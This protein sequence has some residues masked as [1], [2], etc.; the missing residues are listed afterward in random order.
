MTQIDITERQALQAERFA[1]SVRWRRTGAVILGW[2][3]FIGLWA[4]LSQLVFG[5]YM[6]PGPLKIAIFMW[7]ELISTG[8]FLSHFAISIGKVFAGFGIA[9]IIGVPVGYLMGT[10]RYWKSFFHDPVMVTGSIP[11]ITYAVLSLVIFGI[12]LGGPILAVALVSMVY[13]AI[14]VAEGLEGVD[15]GLV[16][17]SHAYRRR[18]RDI[19][20]HVLIPSILPFAFAGIRLSFALAWKVEQLT[21]VFGSSSGVGLMIRKEYEDFSITGVLAWVLLFIGFM[22]LIERFVLVELERWLF[23]WRGPEEEVRR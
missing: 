20:R 16:Q 22:L 7:E 23:R 4:L 13:V 6:L 10:S 11:G 19:L 1:A 12:S 21:E 2:L 17:M 5:P 18:Q 3:G 15:R 9:V 14:N 8:L